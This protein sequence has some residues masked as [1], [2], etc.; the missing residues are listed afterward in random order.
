MSPE[1]KCTCS[2]YP[3]ADLPN[4]LR[5]FLVP[6]VNLALS[7]QVQEKRVRNYI[8]LTGEGGR[9]WWMIVGSTGKS[10]SEYSSSKSVEL[11]SLLLLFW[12]KP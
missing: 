11:I 3:I 1:K 7:I 12:G 9:G 8:Y 4:Q 10:K 5:L 6:S 2:T